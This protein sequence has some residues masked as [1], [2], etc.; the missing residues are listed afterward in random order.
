MYS[1]IASVRSL[2][3]RSSAH[4]N[5]IVIPLASFSSAK[6]ASSKPRTALKST[7][8]S[9]EWAEVAANMAPKAFLKLEPSAGPQPKRN[10]NPFGFYVRDNKEELKRYKEYNVK[11]EEMMKRVAEKYRMLSA[12]E[13]KRYEDLAENDKARY[14]KE[15]D[16]WSNSLTAKDKSLIQYQ[17][18]IRRKLDGRHPR[19]PRDPNAPKIPLNPYIL[20]CQDQRA[21]LQN[22]PTYQGLNSQQKAAHLG[23]LWKGLDEAKKSEYKASF[24]S[25]IAKY[26]E[27]VDRLK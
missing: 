19:V 18:Y 4:V 12:S 5:S 8:N 23:Q 15:Q 9:S 10:L 3:L 6:K 1:L 7:K 17:E 16:A 26:R 20:F 24:E 22:D 21:K 27:E 13:K 11:P 25:A 2:S 14:R